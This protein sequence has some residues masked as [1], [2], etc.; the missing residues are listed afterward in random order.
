MKK[1]SIKYI[2]AGVIYIF[3]TIFV[4]KNSEQLSYSPDNMINNTFT[5]EVKYKYFSED[6]SNYINPNDCPYRIG[7][8]PFAYSFS[9]WLARIKL[10]LYLAL[11]VLVPLWL[12][13]NKERVQQFIKKVRE[14]ET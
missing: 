2:V 8:L 7:E 1:V 6:C 11:L 12:W 5:G 3:F 14:V 9:Q 4:L 13:L 10:K